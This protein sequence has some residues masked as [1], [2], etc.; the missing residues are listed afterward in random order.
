MLQRDHL[1]KAES[2]IPVC[3]R[4]DRCRLKKSAG[5]MGWDTLVMGLLE[6]EI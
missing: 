4:G 3:V 6:V 2:S 1:W 5:A